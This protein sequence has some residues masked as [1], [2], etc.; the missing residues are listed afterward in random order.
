MITISWGK[1][2]EAGGYGH[3]KD[4]SALAQKCVIT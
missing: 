1:I 3:A 4:K 2:G